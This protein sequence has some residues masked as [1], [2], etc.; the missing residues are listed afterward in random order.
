LG[1]AVNTANGITSL[2][3]LNITVPSGATLGETRMRIVSVEASDPAPLSCG[4]QLYGE[5][6]DYK[7]LIIPPT[8][9]PVELL[10]F[11]GFGYQHYNTLK[12]S[13]ASEYNSDYFSLERS[14]NGEQWDYVG[15]TKATGNSTQ[16]VNYLYVDNFRFNGFIY[17]KLNQFDFDGNFKVYGPISINNTHTNKKVVKYINI[18][19]QEVSSE[20]N[21]FIFEVYED[22]TMRKIIR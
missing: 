14:V 19:G 3:P 1:S 21:G 8:G 11:E 13:T 9:L 5:A 2:S 10:Y 4:T 15:T 16:V 18:L 7:L 6:E 22:G 20:T 12:W 17:Y